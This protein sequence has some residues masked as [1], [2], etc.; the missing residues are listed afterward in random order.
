MKGTHQFERFDHQVFFADKDCTVTG[1]SEWLDYETK[2]PL[3]WRI[4]T[5]ITRD[6]TQYRVKDGQVISNLYQPQAFKC[7]D[8]TDVKIGDIVEAVDVMA[9]TLYGQYRNQI[10]VKCKTMRVVTP[11]TR[12]AKD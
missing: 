12:K 1:I 5:V 2:K 11:A 8:K 7:I 3:G 4:D 9:C 6:D 10:S